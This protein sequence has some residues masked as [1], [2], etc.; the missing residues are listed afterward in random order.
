MT[1]IFRTRDVVVFSK[2]LT[3]P[4]LIDDT[5][6]A[7]GWTGGQG[8]VWLDSP[9]SDTF[10][11]TYST[12]EYGGFLLWGSNEPS[13]QY[14]SYTLNQPTYKFAVLCVGAGWIISTL[15]FEQY[16]YQSRQVGPLVP[17]VYVPGQTLYF[18][19][20]GLFTNQDEWTIS[21]DPRAPNTWEIA[22][23][24]SAPS[25]ITNNYLTLR[26]G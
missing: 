8:V 3:Y 1:E 5:M 7:G 6:A 22:T 26:G 19:L 4:V 10:L 12:G 9:T 14:I 2:G 21:G 24:V 25:S 17:N 11:V 18:S 16:T 20:R 23:V 13:D 15:S